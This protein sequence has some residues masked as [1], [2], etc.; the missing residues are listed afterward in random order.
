MLYILVTLLVIVVMALAYYLTFECG[1][2][3][4]NLC[5]PFDRA[6]RKYDNND[7]KKDLN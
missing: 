1:E 5:E 7:D 4:D 2:G 3:I 6:E